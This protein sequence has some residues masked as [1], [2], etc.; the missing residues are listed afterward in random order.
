MICS[1]YRLFISWHLD[2]E[3]KLPDWIS[4]HADKCSD[5]KSFIYLH[6]GLHNVTG[7]NTDESDNSARIERILSK[8]DA[9]RD[10]G[11]QYEKKNYRPQLVFASIIILVVTAGIYFSVKSTPRG[12]TDIEPIQ[13]TQLKLNSDGIGNMNTLFSAVEKPML[14][15]INSLSSSFNSFRDYLKSALDLKIAGRN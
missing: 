5:C 13:L 6:S 14:S 3:K 1:I 7:S 12:R 4:G 10:A 8:I 2:S 9:D 11:R 15:E